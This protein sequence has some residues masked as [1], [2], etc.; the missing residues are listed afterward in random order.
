[1]SAFLDPRVFLTLSKKQKSKVITDIKEILCSKADCDMNESKQASVLSED[2]QL[3][4]M[5]KGSS[6]I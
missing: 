4:A 3:V 6:K 1:M 2:E 5:L